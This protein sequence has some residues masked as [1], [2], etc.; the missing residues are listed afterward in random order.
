MKPLVVLIVVW[1]ITVVLSI[2]NIYTLQNKIDVCHE[3]VLEHKVAVRACCGA[4]Y[5]EHRERVMNR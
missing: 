5:Y 1:I 4:A 3:N 2:F